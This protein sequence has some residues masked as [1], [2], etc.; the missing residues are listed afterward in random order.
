MALVAWGLAD[1]LRRR[2]LIAV[3]AVPLAVVAGMTLLFPGPGWFPFTAGNAA[4]VVLVCG[5]A[6]SPALSPPAALRTA[7]VLYAAVT[8]VLFVVPTM[9]GNNDMR[10]AADIGIPVL[11]CYGAQRLRRPIMGSWRTVGSWT[12]RAT[13]VTGLIL[14]AWAPAVSALP[15]GA[16]VPA[17]QQSFYQP[18]IQQLKGRTTAPVRIEVTPTRYHWES[19]W[20]APIFPLARGRERQLDIGQ[21]PLFYTP[22]PLT[23]TAY[24]SWL[25]H[26]GVSYVALPTAPLDYA[27][28]RRGGA[29]SLRANPRSATGVE[30]PRTGSSGKWSDPPEWSRGRPGW[31]PSNPTG[32]LSSSISPDRSPFGSTGPP[33]GPCPQAPAVSANRP[34]AGPCC[35]APG[36]G[37]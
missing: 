37:R 6:A 35:S 22:G 36:P 32:S 30:E 21:N 12:L 3:G 15:G 2:R 10:L 26:Q 25:L 19:V 11:V 5:L 28:R 9:M 20:V 29:A 16:A 27:A 18:L 23:P 14:W 31:S 1:P 4:A 8:L 7:A 17:S 24:R 33:T 34:P 13:T